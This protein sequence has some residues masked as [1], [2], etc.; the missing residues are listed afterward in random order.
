[1]GDSQGQSRARGLTRAILDTF[2]VIKFSRVPVTGRDF[3]AQN[4]VY[5][6]PTDEESGSERESPVRESVEMGQ[7]FPS[8]RTRQDDPAATSIAEVTESR[9][10]PPIVTVPNMSISD[11]TCDIPSS[12]GAGP[13]RSPAT[14]SPEGAPVVG[15]RNALQSPRGG[16][17]A[18]RGNSEII[19]D[20][21]G[22]ETCPICIVDFEEGDD[23]RVLPCAGKHVFHQACVDQWLLELSS[24]CPLCRQGKLFNISSYLL[25]TE[26][27]RLQIS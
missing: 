26:L 6:K 21:I 16:S 11:R 19:P 18:E 5:P 14:T 27:I 13:S 22:R 7:L 4:P 2:P 24:S 20:S 23:L 1:M 10:I 9:G 15:T 25:I 8:R 17:V 12:P 3:G